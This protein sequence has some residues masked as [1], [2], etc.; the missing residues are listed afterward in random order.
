[1]LISFLHI[2][3]FG[4]S[5]QIETP[6]ADDK[7]FV[8]VIKT[9]QKHANGKCIYVFLFSFSSPSVLINPNTNPSILS[10]SLQ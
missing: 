10:H 8:S 9:L 3:C 7:D 5:L 6:G 2:V 1:M 4:Q